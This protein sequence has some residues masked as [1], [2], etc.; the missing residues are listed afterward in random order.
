M[1]GTQRNARA[2]AEGGQ[3]RGAWR[4]RARGGARVL[5]APHT[6]THPASRPVACARRGRRPVD[7]AAE[8]GRFPVIPASSSAP[9]RRSA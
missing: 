4:A 1:R 8:R 3:L 9:A 7:P 5:H 6:A 2:A